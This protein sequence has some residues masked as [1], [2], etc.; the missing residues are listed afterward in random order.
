MNFT[1][2]PLRT[3]FIAGVR[4]PR[5]AFYSIALAQQRALF[6]PPPAPMRPSTVLVAALFFTSALFAPRVRAQEPPTLQYKPRSL[7]LEAVKYLIYNDL[8]TIT[9]FE[10][11]FN[12]TQGSFISPLLIPRVSG[13]ENNA[14][15]RQFIVDTLKAVNWTVELD[16]FT[17]M[18]PLGEKEFTNIIATKNPAAPKRI[19]VAAHYDSKYFP[20]P[21]VF[22]GATDSAGSCAILLDLATRLNKYFDDKET[23]WLGPVKPP[24]SDTTLQVIFF[25]GEESFGEWSDADS[26]Y[27]SRHLAEKWEAE[28]KLKSIELFVLLDLL[29]GS[30]PKIRNFS[31]ATSVA[32]RH[33]SD[34]ELKLGDNLMLTPMAAPPD[35]E[36][37]TD[38]QDQDELYFV[39]MDRAPSSQNVKIDDDHVP[40]VKRGVPALHIIPT[41]FPDYWHTVRDDAS[42]I[43]PE[44]LND[45]AVILRVFVAEY[46]QLHEGLA[47]EMKNNPT[48]PEN[49]P[50]VTSQTGAESWQKR[51]DADNKA[52]ADAEAADAA[53]A[54]KAAREADPGAA[55]GELEVEEEMEMLEPAEAPEEPQQKPVE[56]AEGEER[57]RDEL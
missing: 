43:V 16:T 21:E 1:R 18:T 12:E 25:D 41:P 37:L 54:T 23:A 51:I 11:T 15:V 6:R 9:R 49:S 8:F 34:I 52:I 20:E 38:F 26:L 56:S 33:L 3:L 13:T 19:V 7:P 47:V 10:T 24:K 45:F 40:F 29:G 36:G 46:L 39:D 17:A 42:V 27:G 14:I 55:G 32:Y 48:T 53:E 5:I 31:P 28:N 57:E 30:H 22:V 50:L 35:D 44:T 2:V 4:R